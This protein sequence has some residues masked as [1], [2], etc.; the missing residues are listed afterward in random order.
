LEVARALRVLRKVMAGNHPT[1]REDSE[2]R[3]C[4]GEG[5]MAYRSLG[6]SEAYPDDP[7]Y[8]EVVTSC[9]CPDCNGSG[10]VP[11]SWRKKTPRVSW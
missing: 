2:C 8:G 6:P 10:Q 1:Y 3:T 11:Q 9:R 7:A 4:L 5:Y